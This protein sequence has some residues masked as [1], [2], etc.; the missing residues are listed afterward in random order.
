[1]DQLDPRIMGPDQYVLMTQTLHSLI[2][3]VVLA[4][5]TAA[6]MMVAHAVIPSLI[7]S[8]DAPVDFNR[9]RPML[10][11]IFVVSLCAAVFAFTRFVILAADLVTQLYPRFAI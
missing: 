1:M 10:Y 7:M 5:N 4:I 3:F 9:F 11:S 8:G 6:S 2:L